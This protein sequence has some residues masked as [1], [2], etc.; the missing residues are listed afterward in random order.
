MSGLTTTVS[1]GEKSYLITS[2]KP[3]GA[4]SCVGNGSACSA[5]SGTPVVFVGR[6]TMDSGEGVGAGLG[7]MIVEEV[8]HGLPKD[9]GEVDV[10]TMAR[11]SCYM[12]LEEGTRVV[13]YGSRDP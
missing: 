2:A 7:R 9:I 5:L 12:R 6:V 10:D 1:T 3:A 13:L 11:T 4:C 8:L